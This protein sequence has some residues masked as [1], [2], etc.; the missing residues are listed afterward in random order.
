MSQPA[1]PLNWGYEVFPNDGNYSQKLVQDGVEYV[2][3]NA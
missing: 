2:V 1:P 3:Y